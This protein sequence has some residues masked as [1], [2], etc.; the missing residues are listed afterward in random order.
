[1]R[2]GAGGALSGTFAIKHGVTARWRGQLNGQAISLI[3]AIP[4]TGLVFGTRML[5]EPLAK[6]HCGMLAG[7]TFSGPATATSATG[8][9]SIARR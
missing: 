3:I 8:T 1:M 2:E 9:G 5:A 7:G 6:G 4:K